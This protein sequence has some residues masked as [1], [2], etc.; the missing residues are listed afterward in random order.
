MRVSITDRS[1]AENPASYRAQLTAANNTLRRAEDTA[2]SD[3]DMILIQR[4]TQQNQI[5][6][7]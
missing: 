7:E 4:N 5:I 2:I 3:E 1:A 6:P